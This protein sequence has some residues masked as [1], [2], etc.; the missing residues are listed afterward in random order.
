MKVHLSINGRP[1]NGYKNIDPMPQMAD[2]LV[3]EYGDLNNLDKLVDDSEVEELWVDN[4]VDFIADYDIESYVG[5]WLSKLRKGGIIHI[6]SVDLYTV[7][8]ALASSSITG[9]YARHLLYGQRG[10]PPR[11]SSYDMA[12]LELVLVQRGMKILRKASNDFV[13]TITAQRP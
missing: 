8:L 9:A 2:G 13:F 3:A 10:Q 5:H 11:M 1:Q 7:S 4:V 6:D 12:E